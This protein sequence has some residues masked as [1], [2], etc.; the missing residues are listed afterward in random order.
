MKYLYSLLLL[1]FACGANVSAQNQTAEVNNAD[2]VV[3]VIAYFCKNDTMDYYFQHVKMKAI[4]NDT[5]INFYSESEF[6]LIVKD[7]TSQGY[8]IELQ[9]ISNRFEVPKDSLMTQMMEK[10]VNSLG[11]VPLIFT[12][13]EYG[14]IQHVENWREVRDFTRKVSKMLTDSLYALKP[15]LENAIAR[16]RF[17]ASLN[18]QFANEQAILNSYEELS[19]L[20][21]LHGKSLTIGKTEG[22]YIDNG[23]PQH[24]RCIASY[25]K[26]S[27][28]DGFDE[29][30]YIRSLSET[31]I[32]GKDLG[33]WLVDQINMMSEHKMT[34]K[35]QQD[36]ISSIDEDAKVSLIESYDFFFNGWPCDMHY[37]K[38]TDLKNVRNMELYRIQWAS[39]SWGV[40]S[41]SEDQQNGVNM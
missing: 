17:E 6:R 24:L 41:G 19:I 11:D 27:E 21:G 36:M 9:P 18:M 14:T 28:D 32:P 39:R 7:S 3:N 15:E 35:D 23:Y 34:E 30:Y 8:K 33:N 2:S 26:S 16:Q 29:D 13:D 1:L 12:T 20:F 40:Y 25:G 10:L 38:V 4:D 37:E 31:T 5:T 22:D